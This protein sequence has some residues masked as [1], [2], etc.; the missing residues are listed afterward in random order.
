VRMST[1]NMAKSNM[2]MRR[3]ATTMATKIDSLG[4]STDEGYD[5]GSD[6]V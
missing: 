3:N 5:E 4:S 1:E 2:S 6:E